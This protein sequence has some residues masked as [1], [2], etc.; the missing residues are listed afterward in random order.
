MTF[1]DYFYWNGLL[2]LTIF[3]VIHLRFIH[4]RP[5]RMIGATPSHVLTEINWLTD[6][7]AAI[8]MFW[9]TKMAAV[10]SCE[11]SFIRKST[12]KM[13]TNKVHFKFVSQI[14]DDANAHHMQYQSLCVV[15][16]LFQFRSHFLMLLSFFSY[17]D[18]E[19][20]RRSLLLH[21]IYLSAIS[22]LVALNILLVVRR[23]RK[24]VPNVKGNWHNFFSA[25]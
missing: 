20:K 11:N 1:L 6:L 22:L 7:L 25:K 8:S 23:W 13:E 12:Q 5:A 4:E 17:P 3:I 15:L 2:S 18:V 21:A 9:N 14:K 19:W 16:I 10:T 24:P